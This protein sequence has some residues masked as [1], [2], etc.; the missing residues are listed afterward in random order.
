MNQE[1]QRAGLSQ[2][3]THL[4]EESHSTFSWP[5]MNS[6]RP[7]SPRFWKQLT[8]LLTHS[9]QA[10]PLWFYLKSFIHTSLT[11]KTCATVS[12]AET[13]G[14]AAS[15]PGGMSAKLRAGNGRGDRVYGGCR[16]WNSTIHTLYIL[17]EAVE[18]TESKCGSGDRTP[19]VGGLQGRLKP[20]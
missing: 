7:P 18:A 17:C 2:N 5:Q 11:V 9:S 10:V 3:V 8:K 15:R 14:L 20:H 12:V 19:Q 6:W 1:E 16:V 13:I 4:E